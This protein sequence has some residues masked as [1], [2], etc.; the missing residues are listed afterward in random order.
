MGSRLAGVDR[1]A[2]TWGELPFRFGDCQVEG[3]PAW[4]A[5][6]KVAA[7]ALTLAMAVPTA[8]MLVVAFPFPRLSTAV[9]RSFTEDFTAST[10]VLY[11]APAA[12]AT[13]SRSAFTASRAAWIPS[14][15]SVRTCGFVS[16]ATDPLRS[17]SSVQTVRSVVVVAELDF[18]LELQ[19]VTVTTA[20]TVAAMMN[21]LSLIVWGI[22][23]GWSRAESSEPSGRIRYLAC[24]AR[25]P[26]RWLHEYSDACML[27]L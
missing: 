5:V 25:G 11:L 14:L 18:E 21:D 27:I 7:V 23:S 15:P 8:W 12:A 9:W 17:A 19:P 13:L 3:Q 4:S 6:I 26:C 2:M 20:I 22:L 10:W 1:G 16:A 24:T